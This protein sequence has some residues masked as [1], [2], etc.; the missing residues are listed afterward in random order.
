MSSTDFDDRPILASSI[1]LSEA[2]IEPATPAT[3]VEVGGV[4]NTASAMFG[5]TSG[6]PGNRKVKLKAA[7]KRPLLQHQRTESS[8][9][10]STTEE[11]SGSPRT[12]LDGGP[13]AAFAR[14]RIGT[15]TS[16]ETSIENPTCIQG[17]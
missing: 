10:P 12:T 1:S 4:A 15:E 14:S 16:L 17:Y 3:A 9:L 11:E 2:E 7:Y 8:T 6:Q 13:T 5:A